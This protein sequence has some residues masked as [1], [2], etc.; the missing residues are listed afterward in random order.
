MLPKTE[1][2][3]NLSSFEQQSCKL[4]CNSSENFIALRDSPR[5]FVAVP[6]M[7]GR[8]GTGGTARQ[9]GV[10]FG[11]GAAG[12]WDGAP[13]GFSGADVGFSPPWRVSFAE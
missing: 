6:R 3:S 1:S 13:R 12:C 11:G 8:F 9:C 10:S 2:N 4:L 7:C 5:V